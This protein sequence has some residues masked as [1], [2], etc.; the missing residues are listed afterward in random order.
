LLDIG[1]LESGEMRLQKGEV[2]VMHIIDEI[3]P[4]ISIQAQSSA[5]EIHFEL[6]P[7]LPTMWADDDLL[8]RVLL[9]LLA[10]AVKFSRRDSQVF[11]QAQMNEEEIVMSIRDQ[12][13]GIRKEDQQRIFEKFGQVESRKQ[14]RRI[15]T[16]LGLTFCKLAIEAH[17]GRIWVDSEPG[18]GSTFF[19]AVPIRPKDGN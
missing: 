12:G 3:M 4:L 5:V 14:G 1:K 15:S 18:N 7:D 19:V 10:N 11:V 6:A 17:G 2:E 13:E 16:G 8:Q 9:N